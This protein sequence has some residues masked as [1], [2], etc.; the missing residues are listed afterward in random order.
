MDGA[1]PNALARVMFQYSWSVSGGGGDQSHHG[2]FILLDTDD[3][4]TKSIRVVSFCGWDEDDDDDFVSLN[5]CN[6]ADSVDSSS[7]FECL[8]CCCSCLSDH[9]YA[10]PMDNTMSRAAHARRNLLML[11]KEKN[12]GAR[13]GSDI[14]MVDKRVAV[15]VHLIFSVPTKIVMA[16]LFFVCLSIRL[17]HWCPNETKKDST[18]TR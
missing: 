6:E 8:C 13:V 18:W 16:V 4:G 5:D 12:R 17:G 10:T 7:L 9:M 14:A 1:F 11:Q 15:G 3:C 2:T